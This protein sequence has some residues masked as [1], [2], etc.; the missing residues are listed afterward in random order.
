LFLYDGWDIIAVMQHF[1]QLLESYTRGVGLAGDI[2]T[3][4]AVTHHA[5][6]WTNGTF[7]AHHN[8][9][10]DIVVTRTGTTTVGTYDYSAFGNLKSQ[11]GSDVCRFKFSSKELDRV[12]G[13]YYYGYRFYAPQWQR[14]VIGDAIGEVGGINL[15]GFVRN[16]PIAYIDPRGAVA[17]TVIAEMV[18][19]VLAAYS[20]DIM[21]ALCGGCD[22]VARLACCDRVMKLAAL[23]IATATTVA[24]LSCAQWGWGAP[25]CVAAVTALL[26]DQ[27]RDLQRNYDDCRS[28]ALWKK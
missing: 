15:Y 25:V 21:R 2:G 3:I 22:V 9:R 18:A 14:W 4:A 23:A 1:G 24:Y 26:Y 20:G 13:F 27:G 28:G 12:T 19:Q 6:S 7:Y 10:G 8:H 11:I 17:I 16:A 5:G